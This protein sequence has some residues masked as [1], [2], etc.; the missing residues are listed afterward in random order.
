[1]KFATMLVVDFFITFVFN[2]IFSYIKQSFSAK[3]ESTLRTNA[4]NHAYMIFY[5]MTVNLSTKTFL[6]S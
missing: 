5:E 6:L 4:F 3:A 1:M 2:C